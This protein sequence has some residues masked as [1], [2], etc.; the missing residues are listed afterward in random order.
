MLRI[1][2]APCWGFQPNVRFRDDPSSGSG[3]VPRGRTDGQ[4]DKHDEAILRMHLR[5]NVF[6][7]VERTVKLAAP[8][9]CVQHIDKVTEFR[10]DEF[11]CS[12][13]C[14]DSSLT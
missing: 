3:V 6:N 1:Q 7:K 10:A 4:T 14:F 2:E 8:I 11:I 13:V 9:Y 5:I 12:T